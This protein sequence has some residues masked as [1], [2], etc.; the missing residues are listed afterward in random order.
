MPPVDTTD[1]TAYDADFIVIGGG[2]GGMAAA[3]EASKLGLKTI[4]FD[5]VKPTVHGTKWG[6]GGTC[7]N[8]GCVPK[9]LMHYGAIMGVAIEH[10]AP[11]Y[12]WNFGGEVTHDWN[13]MASTGMLVCVCLC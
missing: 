4:L 11:K 6:L 8:V 3:K 9:K 2:S 13:K 7:V 12:G 10:D 5:Y 1:T